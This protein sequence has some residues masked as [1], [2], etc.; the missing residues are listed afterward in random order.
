MVLAGTSL[1][2]VISCPGDCCSA[3]MVTALLDVVV[4]SSWSRVTLLAVEAIKALECGGVNG[5]CDCVQSGVALSES[6][7]D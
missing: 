1:S 4:G 3:A 6:G 5:A 7:Y 2:K